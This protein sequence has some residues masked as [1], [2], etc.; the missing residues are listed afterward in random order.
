MG[1]HVNLKTPSNIPPLCFDEILDM[2]LMLYSTSDL[3]SYSH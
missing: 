3:G 2:L 1:R